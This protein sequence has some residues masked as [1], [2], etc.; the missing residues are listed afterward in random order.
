MCSLIIG[1]RFL[2]CLWNRYFPHVLFLRLN[3]RQYGIAKPAGCHSMQKA[4]SWGCAQGWRWVARRKHHA[5]L[6]YSWDM[7]RLEVVAPRVLAAFDHLNWRLCPSEVINVHEHKVWRRVLGRCC[8]C[9]DCGNRK[10]GADNNS[11][12]TVPLSVSYFDKKMACSWYCSVA[13]PILYQLNTIDCFD[14]RS[15]R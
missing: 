7:W 10:H 12:R 6:S 3:R 14:R 13:A 2:Q 11:H 1:V 8:R 15:M 4:V 9:C 5:F